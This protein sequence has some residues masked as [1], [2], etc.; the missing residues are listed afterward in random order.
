MARAGPLRAP[1]AGGE[2]GRGVS[3][4]ARRTGEAAA[5][6]AAR[7]ARGARE[8]GARLRRDIL[9]AT[10]WM[11]RRRRAPPG[12]A[13]GTLIAD[14]AAPPPVV[15]MM[16]WG[17]EGLV[18]ADGFDVARIAEWRA[19][20]PVVWLD[21]EGLGD[22]ELIARIGE[23]FGLH[24]LALEDAV[25]VGQ[26]AKVERYPN[27]LFLVT[28]LL[29]LEDAVIAE[30]VG[31]FVGRGFVVS[32]QERPGDS[33][34]PVRARARAGRGRMRAGGAGYL[35]YAII[36]SV[37]DV[38]FPILE[39]FGERLDAIETETIEHP[40]DGTMAKIHAARRN[41][42]VL[43]RSIWPAR[44][45]LNSLVREPG[46]FFEEE[47]RLYLQDCYDHAIQVMDLTESYREV[48]SGL[49]DIYLS[50]L[51]HRMNEVM[52]VLTMFATIFIPLGFIAGLYGMNFDPSRSPY[53]MPELGW[54]WGYPF[55]LALMGLVA[56]GLL[57][58]FRRKGWIGRPDV[59]LTGRA[60]EGGAAGDG[61]RGPTPPAPGG[62]GR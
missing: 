28:H 44:E 33:M 61:T 39:R 48:G 24:R 47:D 40:N 52:K 51:S 14:P 55:A 46:A 38:Y 21:V 23:V 26:R 30:Q 22:V 27:H 12:T 50:S 2:T 54:R 60:E 45:M 57:W 29:A 36:D 37:V 8:G 3:D 49:M 5:R 42:M 43:R 62:E 6:I 41:L 25:N 11:P 20:W 17:P 4:P 15:R 58:Y 18:E 13:P 32:L 9:R 35:A 53:N 19:R 10:P 31:L 7:A 34:E 16:A 1:R 59:L 56:V